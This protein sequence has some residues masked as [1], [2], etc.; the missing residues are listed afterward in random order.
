MDIK[1]ILAKKKFQVDEAG[2]KRLNP[3]WEEAV[4]FCR[5]CNLPTDRMFIVFV[6]KLCKKYGAGK[7]YALK[8]WLK[9]ATYEPQKIKGLLV[10]KLNNG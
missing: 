10:W 9:D 7:V 6:L 5:Y 4:E 1:E 2:A 8:S 3:K